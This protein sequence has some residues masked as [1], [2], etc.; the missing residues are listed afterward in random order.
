MRL[1]FKAPHLEDAAGV[2]GIKVAR[3]VARVHAGRL[4]RDVP[5]V[6]LQLRRICLPPRR[7]LQQ[8]ALRRVAGQRGCLAR[9]LTRRG[10][11]GHAQAA[12]G[13]VKS[14]AVL[15]AELS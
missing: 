9:T 1:L 12:A 4:G 14:Y 3:E 6:L 5:S 2:G 7:T 8:R 15:N 11:R 13:E 10:T